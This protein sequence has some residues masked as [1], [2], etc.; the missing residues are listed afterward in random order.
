ML[1]LHFRRFFLVAC[2]LSAPGFRT[3]ATATTGPDEDFIWVEGE[4]A[5][6]K[7]VSPHPWYSEAVRKEQMSGGGWL[8]HFSSTTDG[9]ARYDVSAAKD[10]DYILWVRA[11]PV[12]SALAFQV[13]GG[14]WSEIDTSKAIDVINIAADD[15]YDLR[16]LGWMRAGTVSLKKGPVSIGF[17]MHSAV[18]HHGAI[19]CFVL[20]LRS[21]EPRGILKPGEVQPPPVVPELSDANLRYWIDFIRPADDDKKWERLDWRTELGAALEEAKQ[22][23]RPILLW[24]M[25][26]HPLGCT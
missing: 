15:R 3:Q 7:Q 26:G 5:T 21:Y 23:Q 20:T 22:L 9:T 14:A 19:D 13:N 18:S 17:K 11:N 10:G 1:R 6:V 16:C 25:N 2:L 8:S 24:A 4:N 12:G